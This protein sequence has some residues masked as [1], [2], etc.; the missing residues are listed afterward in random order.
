VSGKA[1]QKRVVAETPSLPSALLSALCHSLCP[2]TLSQSTIHPL[3]PIMQEEAKLDQSLSESVPSTAPVSNTDTAPS[4]SEEPV[5][6]SSTESL[7]ETAAVPAPVSSTEEVKEVI[8]AD[9]VGVDSI[10]ENMDNLTI[11]GNKSLEE[12]HRIQAKRSHLSA[13]IFTA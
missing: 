2:R 3:S 11:F 7:T 5:Q 8:P 10:S 1:V 4:V 12:L 13:G 6:S 9:A